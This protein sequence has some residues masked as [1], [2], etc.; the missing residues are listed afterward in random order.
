MQVIGIDFETYY[1]DE[2]SLRRMT[3]EEYIRDP[4]FELIMVG[5]S[6]EEG[7]KEWFSGTPAEIREYLVTQGVETSVA[8]GHNL[9]EFDALI[10]T[11]VLGLRAKYWQCTLAIARALGDGKTSQSLAAIAAR[12]GLEAKGDEVVRAKGKRRADF[13]EQELAAYGE[14]CAHDARLTRQVYARQ[15]KE[16]P[17]QEKQVV[18]WFAR[19]F[20]EPRLEVDGPLVA[21]VANYHRQLRQRLLHQVASDVGVY[22]ILGEVDYEAVRKKLRSDVQFAA[23]LRSYGVTP[24]EKLSKKKT[25]TAGK[26]VYTYAFAKTDAFM[27]QLLLDPNPKVAAAA[28]AR[29]GVKSSITETRLERFRGIAKRGKL[30]APFSYGKTHTH[31]AAGAG[32]INLQNMGRPGPVTP[33]TPTGAPVMVG[34]HLYRLVAHSGDMAVRLQGLGGAVEEVPRYEARVAGLRDCIVAP[35]GMRIVIVDSSAIELRVAH[36]LAG[37]MDT[38][39]KIRAGVQMYEEF[40]ADLYGY[41]VNK[42][43]HPKERQHGKVGMLQLQY[44]AGAGSFQAQARVM[45]GVLLTAEESEYTVDLYRTKFSQI[46]S[47]WYRCQRMIEAMHHGR[48]EYIDQWGLCHTGK[49]RIVLPG[50]LVL[51]YHGLHQQD[52]EYGREWVYFDKETRREKRLYGGVIFENLC[53]ALARLIVFEQS[54]KLERRWGT[55]PDTGVCMTAHDE[56]CLLVHEQDSEPCLA[57][58]IGTFRQPPKWWDWLPLDAE[59]D[60][61]RRYGT[62][63]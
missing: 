59:G 47:M 36:A 24:G 20:A 39:E 27:E 42:N 22:N 21:I 38:I 54:V 44:Q 15:V 45:G 63:K 37:Q 58:A 60:V 12:Y 7:H 28:E 8:V 56:A 1:D 53:Q 41:P 16:L 52:G 31:R 9:A 13:S 55:T 48:E 3:S 43:D 18:H 35:E 14:Y 29:I 51:H 40:A 11:E 34:D 61:G 17:P 50:G 32:K 23:L 4:R 57:D 49:D 62:A 2:Y 5:V 33:D 19:M 26:P 10:M 6:R 30:P 46:R 25:E